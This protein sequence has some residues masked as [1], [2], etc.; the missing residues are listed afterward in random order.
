[1]ESVIQFHS[2]QSLRDAYNSN[3]HLWNDEASFLQPCKLSRTVWPSN[4]HYAMRTPRNFTF[5]MMRQVF[6]NCTSK[7]VQIILVNAYNLILNLGKAS[8]T[9]IADL[10]FFLTCEF[11]WRIFQQIWGRPKLD[12]A[13]GPTSPY[14]SRHKHVHAHVRRS[15]IDGVD[16]IFL[17]HLCSNKIS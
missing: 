15:G 10:E 6:Y 12:H 16:S 8:A 14:L 13:P 4:N 2:K 9:C 3:P 1:M 7:V 11:R 5:V 17:R